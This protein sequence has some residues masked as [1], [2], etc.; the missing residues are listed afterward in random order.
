MRR[1][2]NQVGSGASRH[3]DRVQ[4]ALPISR[5][6][7]GRSAQL[8][9]ATIAGAIVVAV[10]A[11]RFLSEANSMGVEDQSQPDFADKSHSGSNLPKHGEPEFI[12]ASASGIAVRDFRLFV[13]DES[14]AN[15]LR[16]E[17]NDLG[18]GEDCLLRLQ[19]TNETATPLRATLAR[20]SCACADFRADGDLPSH[21]EAEW[22]IRVRRSGMSPVTAAGIQIPHGDGGAVLLSLR[23]AEKI[24][25]RLFVWTV[26][27]E[28]HDAPMDGP[29]PDLRVC[30]LAASDSG[31]VPI[32]SGC[33]EDAVD[34]ARVGF[35]APR[36]VRSGTNCGDW[37]W[38]SESG[39]QFKSGESDRSIVV[40]ADG[41]RAVRV[42]AR[43]SVIDAL[44]EATEPQKAR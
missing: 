36:L 9:L 18:S 11:A 39:V 35:A 30:V 42:A 31:V 34:A 27:N 38:Y 28:K 14:L 20:A 4:S 40:S 41:W 3:S 43:V 5:L 44:L 25:R 1:K 37:I 2:L 7:F 6:A 32:L 15:G 19:V 10:V 13:T 12:N 16:I 17:V 23:V 26:A 21:A 24:S 33:V 22:S 29:Q 8:V